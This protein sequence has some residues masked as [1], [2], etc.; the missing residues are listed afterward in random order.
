METP[1]RTWPLR[2]VALRF[3]SDVWNE[4]GAIART[5]LEELVVADFRD[6]APLMGQPDGAVGLAWRI[7]R[8]HERYPDL[9]MFVEDTIVE[10]E[11]VTVRWSGVGSLRGASGQPIR[12]GGIDIFR[13]VD[14]RLV[15][16][17][18]AWDRDCLPGETS[19]KDP[20]PDPAH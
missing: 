9:R 5:A 12:V 4:R 18:H 11:R 10:G 3:F 7:E 2:Q 14:Q 13:I 15:E 19:V 8:M 6:H 16:G 17:W 1:A 20:Q